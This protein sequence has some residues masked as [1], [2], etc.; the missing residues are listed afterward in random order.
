MN[1]QD[2]QDYLHE[3]LLG[4]A[5]LNDTITAAHTYEEEGILTNNKGIVVHCDDGSIFQITIRKYQ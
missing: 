1:E 4:D 3:T 2:F 5:E